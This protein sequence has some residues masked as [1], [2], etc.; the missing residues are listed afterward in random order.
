MNRQY[1]DKLMKWFADNY[2][3]DLRETTMNN[4]FAIFEKYTNV[5]FDKALWWHLENDC[6]STF[7]APGKITY[8]LHQID[9]EENGVKE[10]PEFTTLWLRVVNQFPDEQ[11]YGYYPDDKDRKAWEG[12]YD[13]VYRIPPSHR[14]QAVQ[15][16]M[17]RLE[18]AAKAI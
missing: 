17:K 10:Y 6:Y 15:D 3:V 9:D 2:D 7:P 18:S 11:N 12:L 13:E 14:P 1:F 16:V 8:A 5:E 4:W